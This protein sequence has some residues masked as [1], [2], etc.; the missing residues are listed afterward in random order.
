VSAEVR[1][2]IV[3]GGSYNWGPVLLQDLAATPELTGTI[4]LHDIDPDAADELCRLGRRLMSAARSGFRVETETDQQEA[5]RDADF[6]VVTIT[7]GGLAAME[8][9]LEI[10]RRYGIVQAVGDTVGP[11]GLARAL[12]N[13][14]VFVELARTMEAVCPEAWLLNLTNPMAACVRAVTKTSTIKTV[15][16]C[17]EMFGVRRVLSRLFEAA[18]EEI[19]LQIAG[20]NHLTWLLQASIRGQDGRAMLQTYLANG[21][22]IPLREVTAPHLAP[23]QDHWRVKLALFAIYGYLPAAGDRHVAEFFPYFLRQEDNGGEAWVLPTLIEH[24]QAMAEAARA[25]VRAW[26]ADENPLPTGRSQE[27]VVDVIRALTT[28]RP[29]TIVANLPNQGQIDNLPRDAVVETRAVVM[30]NGIA[31]VSVGALS[32]SLLATVQN[33]VANQ[34]LIVEAALTGNRTLVNQAFLGDP[35]VRDINSTPR[36]VDE[37]IEANSAYLPRFWLSPDAW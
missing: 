15:G 5:L 33:H 20:T 34:E 12:R 19:E 9:D 31:P 35:L 18:P 27:E 14:P 6:V 16:L 13:V 22:T 29:Q 32:T 26:L 3:G 36:L 10:P 24:R 23:F 17:H 1:I 30:A 28:G 2:C 4:V 7:T 11:G 37:L 8:H 25:K 21:G